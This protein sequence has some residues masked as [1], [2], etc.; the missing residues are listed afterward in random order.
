MKRSTPPFCVSGKTLRGKGNDPCPAGGLVGKRQA[1]L[2]FSAADATFYK[3]RIKNETE[4]K[5][6]GY[7]LDYRIVPGGRYRHGVSRGRREK[8]Y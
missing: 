3:G 5:M 8:D 4:E 6:G 2:R 7:V 1:L